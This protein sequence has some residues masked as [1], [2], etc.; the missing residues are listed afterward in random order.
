MMKNLIVAT[1]LVI[2]SAGAQGSFSGTLPAPEFP[3]GLEWLN[4]DRPLSL[5]DLRG[6]IV[7]LD[8]WTYGCINC[9]H[10]IPDLKRLEEKYAEELVV[11]GVHSAKFSHEAETEN[12]RRIIDRY[13]IEHPVVN[14]RDFVIWR[15]YGIRAWPSFILID[16]TGK[17]LGHHAGEGIFE[18]FDQVIAGMVAEFDARGLLDRRPLELVSQAERQPRTLLRF[19]GKVLA[20]EA[21]GRLFIADTGHHRVVVTD[22]DGRVLEVV[23]SGQA[24]FSDGGFS[25]ASFQYPQGL[26]L[27]DERTLFVADTGN[28]SL[29]RVDLATE[30][31]TTAAG[32]GAQSYTHFVNQAAVLETG[33][34]SPWDVLYLEGQIYIA[35]AGQHQLWRYDPASETLHRHAGSGY[36]EL[37]DGPLLRAGLN[38]P[39]G[40]ASDGEVLF[41]A[42]SEASAVR[43]AEVSPGGEL[44]TVV[45]I[46]LFDFGD[47]DGIGDEVRLQHPKGV[48]YYE[49][50]LYLADT[51]NNKIKRLDPESREST[52]LLGSGEPGWRDGAEAQFYEPGGL[53]VAE[54]RLYIADTN[55][56]AVRVADLET[57]TVETLAL[58]DPLGL[59]RHDV[60]ADFWGSVVTL[61]PREVA[62]GEGVIAL[63]VTLPESYKVNTL[64][65]LSLDWTSER[66]SVVFADSSQEVPDAVFPLTLETG[67]RFD[68]DDTLTADLVVYYCEEEALQLC[69]VD[70]VRLVVPVSVSD[71]GEGALELSYA[72]PPLSQ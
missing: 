36:E 67:A 21:G 27:A 40:L 15:T 24:G 66:G 20:D 52:T 39:S 5:E 53:S 42:D 38:Q 55:N 60:A 3:E 70:E 54:G 13:E 4:T 41:V 69:L 45:G 33:L 19:P 46:G 44:T 32:I 47:V 1:L 11:I 18:L 43:R 58:Y 49:N 9:L 37:R 68:G 63:T 57:L 10:V 72:V 34:N 59:L 8:F 35:M 17:V 30:T 51:Y 22:L 28:H 64:A 2:L 25:Q 48:A 14:D 7:L 12:I 31:V 29:R 26:A 71:E 23:G 62:A 16:P 61:E 56:H 50:A 65:P 6:R